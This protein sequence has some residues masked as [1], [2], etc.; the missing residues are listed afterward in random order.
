VSHGLDLGATVRDLAGLITEVTGTDVC[1][2]HVVDDER[3]RLTLA[4]ATPPFDALAGQIELAVGEGVAGW[5]AQHGKPAIVA[6]KW[7]DP[8]YKYI[9][10]LRGEDF[11]ALV[12]VPM[13]TSRGQLVGVLNVHSRQSRSFS[14]A[15]VSLLTHIA[16]LMAG[17]VDNARLYQRLAEREAELER[18]ARHTLELQET[19]RK[20]L[21]MEIHDGIS[22]PIVSL[23]YHLCAAADA[24]PPPGPVIAAQLAAARELAAAALEETRRAIFGLR[25]PLLDD[26]GLGACLHRLARDL[27]PGL[28]ASVEVDEV[29]LDAHVETAI[30]RIA[31]EALQNVVK[32]SRAQ[33]V[34]IELRV[35]DD[36]VRLVIA[37]DGAGFDVDAVA[38]DETGMSYGIAGLHA[39][40]ELIGATLE[41]VSARGVGTSVTVTA[42][43]TVTPAV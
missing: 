2:V 7:T 30:Y 1:F 21:A 11:S 22:Q 12:S 43:P 13:T 9:P 4:G 41:I 17:A 32:H 36:G 24:A 42:R 34:D 37:D 20:R 6:D 5:V 8:R 18:F 27:A 10:E 19:E 31:Q 26:L 39:R 40:S 15:D 33:H 38:R 3:R 23:Y 28:A 14:D 35:L 16:G 29:E 25:P